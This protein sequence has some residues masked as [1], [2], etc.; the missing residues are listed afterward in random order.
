M[1]ADLQ[2][3]LEKVKSTADFYDVEFDSINDTNALGDNALHC[4]CVWGDIAAASLL[5]ENGIAIN[6]RGEGG[7]TPLNLALEF[8]HIQLA[9]YLIS[10]GADTS[11]IGADFKYD[12]EKHDKHLQGMEAEMQNLEE[13][14]KAICSVI[15]TDTADDFQ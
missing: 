9:D 1:N 5:V 3:L 7:F 14:L 15:S 6:Q 11:I 10:Q 8:G 2:Q 13:Q 12:S 4:V